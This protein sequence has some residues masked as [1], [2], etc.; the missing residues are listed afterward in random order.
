MSDTFSSLFVD[1]R[2]VKWAKCDYCQG[3]GQFGY[4]MFHDGTQ[5]HVQIGRNVPAWREFVHRLETEAL[6]FAFHFTDEEAYPE[7]DNGRG[8]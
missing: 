4:V 2:A 6:P 8:G 5:T 7:A 3:W 1:P